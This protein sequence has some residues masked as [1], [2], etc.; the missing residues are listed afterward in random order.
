MTL[1]K[2]RKFAFRSLVALAACSSVPAFAGVPEDMK[3]LIEQRQAVKAYELGM[4]HAEMLGDPLF[5]YYFGIAAVDAGRASIGVLALERFMLQDPSND[6]AR[7]ELGRGYYVI[8]DFARAKREFEA[9]AA[10]NPP[11]GVQTTIKRFLTAMRDRTK[12]K[13][14]EVI[15]FLEMGL[16]V[17]SNANS[18]LSSPDITLPVFGPVKLDSSALAKS[19]EYAQILG[20][21]SVTKP[22]AGKFKAI[23]NVSGTTLNYSRTSNYDIAAATALLAAGYATER[24]NITLGPTGSFALLSGAKYRQ[25]TGAASSVRV[26]VGKNGTFHTEASIINLKYFGLNKN[27]SARLFALGAGFDRQF[28][29]LPFKPIVSL[30]GS[31]AQEKNRRNRSD[32][33]RKIVGGRADLA[34]FPS[35]KTSVMLGYN[36]SR[37]TYEGP[38]LLFGKPRRDWFSSYDATVQFLLQ[39]G[40]SV[41][42]Q[43]QITEDDANIP[44]YDYQQKIVSVALRREW[45]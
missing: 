26:S 32:F 9:V 22:V 3:L 19:S 42:L 38:D 13:R 41:R 15:S 29:A 1:T 40:L 21:V 31:Y 16:G 34:L 2:I 14:M 35:E 5:D 20:G 23:L 30:S 25:G 6:L 4:Q 44:L 11:M 8:G 7:L 45:N 33:S 24:V 43:G 10:K 18:G 37:W 27:R 12:G 39:P 36:L 28:P 17:T